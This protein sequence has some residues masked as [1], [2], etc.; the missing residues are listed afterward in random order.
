M[1]RLGK[2]PH[3]ER[4]RGMDEGIVKALNRQVTVELDSS[5]LYI[6]MAEWFDGKELGGFANWLRKQA[7]E[8]VG[9]ALVL[10]N[11]LLDHDADVALGKVDAKRHFFVSVRDAMAKLLLRG[12]FIAA[13]VNRVLDMAAGAEDDETRLLL[14]WFAAVQLEE[15]AAVID[16]LGRVNACRG[17][18]GP[19][20][21]QLDAE[22]AGREFAI[23]ELLRNRHSTRYMVG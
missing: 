21:R 10:F 14:T 19:E 5:Y 12:K 20:L 1:R 13:G 2:S 6:Q 9:H 3:R 18:D 16:M 7:H 11:Y 22:L 17:E 15:E 8:E 23:P 4:Y